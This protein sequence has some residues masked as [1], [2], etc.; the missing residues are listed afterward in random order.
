MRSF[1]ASPPDPI[2][3]V[4]EDEDDDVAE[5][6][7]WLTFTDRQT[8]RWSAFGGSFHFIPPGPL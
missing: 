1:L 2:T 7:Q 4:G 3:P 6:Q 8:G 5:A